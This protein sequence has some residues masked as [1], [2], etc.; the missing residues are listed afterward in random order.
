LRRPP[1]ARPPQRLC[2]R[3]G[4]G[5]F[6]AAPPQAFT[7][8]LAQVPADGPGALLRALAHAWRARAL[9][10]SGKTPAAVQDAADALALLGAPIALAHT[11]RGR[12]EPQWT[13][14]TAAAAARQRAAAAQRT[15]HLSSQARPR[16]AG[17]PALSPRGSEGRASPRGVSAARALPD[18]PGGPVLPGVSPERERAVYALLCLLGALLESPAVDDVAGASDAYVPPRPAPP[19]ARKPAAGSSDA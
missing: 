10:E 13:D 17:S 1:E 7:A 9:V 5:I 19:G 12:L 3:F 8:C 16:G 14:P 11:A 2:A 6:N 15:P 18:E 4:W